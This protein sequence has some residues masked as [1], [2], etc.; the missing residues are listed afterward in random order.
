MVQDRARFVSRAPPS[1]PP[2]PP[3][4]PPPA[5]LPP[6]RIVPLPPRPPSSSS[7][8]HAYNPLDA[9]NAIAPAAIQGESRLIWEASWAALG[10]AVSGG[11]TPHRDRI[12]ASLPPEAESAAG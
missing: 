5:P 11:M 1:L 3:R 9:A 7:P 4:P 10:S 8:P 12:L 2:R 6:S